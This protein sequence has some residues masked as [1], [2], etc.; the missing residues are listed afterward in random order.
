[1]CVLCGRLEDAH[2]LT[3]EELAV[4]AAGATNK[5]IFSDAAIIE[6]LQDDN[7]AWSP[8]KTIGISFL[9]ARPSISTGKNYDGF[10]VLTDP[11]KET[12]RLALQLWS[13]VADLTFKEDA[14]SAERQGQITFANSD[15]ITEGVWGFAFTSGTTRPVWINFNGGTDTWSRT[16]GSYDL[17]ATLHEIGHALG[18][19]HPSDYNASDSGEETYANSADFMQDNRLYTIMSYFNATEIG[20]N[21]GRKYAATPMVYD[22]LAVQDFYGRN[23][24]TRAGD[25]V[26]GFNSTA[27]RSVLDFT[28]NTQPVVTI[29]DGGGRNS[30]DLSG[31]TNASTVDLRPGSYSDVA[32]LRSNLSIAFATYVADVV[33]G[34]GTDSV[35]D[36]VLANRIVTGAGD[37][38]ITVTIG[39]DSVDGG[40]GT[41][42]LQIQGSKDLYRAI[43]NADGTLTLRGPTGSILVSNVE[44]FTFSGT[45]GQT[46]TR[47]QVAALD[48]SGMLY[49]A[50][51]P[52]LIL[53]F[54]GNLTAATNHWQTFGRNENRPLDGFNALGYLASNKDLI[55]AFGYD[56]TAAT[57]HYISYGYREGR[58]VSGFDGLA[59]LAS[60]T[61]RLDKIGLSAVAGQIDYIQN[62][63]PKGLSIT[64]DGLAY[65]ASYADLRASIGMNAAAGLQHYLNTGVK[66][67]REVR[68]DVAN[69]LAS[70][71][72][73]ARAFGYNLDRA[74]FHYFYYGV[75][76]GRTDDSFNVYDYAGSNPTVVASLGYDVAALTKHYITTGLAQGLVTTR[77]DVTAYAI[78]NDITGDGWQERATKAY[79]AGNRTN[80]T[81]FGTD[82]DKHLLTIGKA[83]TG[84]FSNIDDIDW[85][86]FRGDA[87]TNYKVTVDFLTASNS[88]TLAE[89]SLRGEDNVLVTY[90]YGRYPSM[91]IEIFTHEAEDVY[92]TL[93]A[94][95]STAKDYKITVAVVTGG[96]IAAGAPVAAAAAP[97][98]DMVARMES[99]AID[100][101]W[102]A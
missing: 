82:Q 29:W 86:T 45:A 88:S 35:R 80:G 51:N 1:M 9:T 28:V 85:F 94:W 42:I 4:R 2:E 74:Y 49:V 16:P 48:F 90:E 34:T 97:D 37:D 17:S 76:E 52:D 81:P 98:L 36:N 5:P 99:A 22:L 71:T 78:Q 95:S 64:F 40:A 50:A 69:Y 70:N 3:T 27:E 61:S 77:F 83:E 79:L 32:G 21:H 101:Y 26:Y 18:L 67:Y 15:T 54:G 44:K 59:W 57:M 62:G 60:D 14:A 65:V 92:I 39:N 8:N 91:S 56:L 31:F 63:A 7:G 20:G 38:A 96:A 23:Y 68:F 102:L 73:L 13:D 11:Q 19:N 84:N 58:A 6:R 12:V 87:Y 41:D 10:N 66:E 24:A 53:A 55:A 47:A 46:L 72:D 33:T 89:L 25:T 43:S 100:N 75:V 30:L 93:E